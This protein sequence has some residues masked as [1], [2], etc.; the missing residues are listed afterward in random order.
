MLGTALFQAVSGAAKM[1]GQPNI[2]M[3][4]KV[5]VQDEGWLAVYN[6]SSDSIQML[7]SDMGVDACSCGGC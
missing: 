1:L 7:L 6:D 4:T 5:S 3:K 2:V